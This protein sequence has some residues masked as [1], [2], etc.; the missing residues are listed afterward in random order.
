MEL[1]IT[2]PRVEW[3]G[4]DIIADHDDMTPQ[5]WRQLRRSGIGGSDAGAIMQVSRYASPLTVC[6]EKTGRGEDF[7]G[8]EATEV[9]NILEPLIRDYIVVP[10]L[11]DHGVPIKDIGAAHHTYR[12]KEWPWMLANIDG[13]IDLDL[14]DLGEKR[15]GLEIKTG[16]SFQLKDWGGMDGDEIPETYYAQVQHYMA[17][18][19]VTEWVVFGLIGNRRV[20]R[21]VHRNETY[22]AN[23]VEEEREV[24]RAIES[25]DPLQFPAPIGLDAED[26]AIR[27]LTTPMTDE[28]VDLSHIETIIDR[29]QSLSDEIKDMTKAKKEAQQII[30]ATMGTAKTGH[31][32]RYTV[33]RTAYVKQQFDAAQYAKDHPDEVADYMREIEIDFPRVKEA[34]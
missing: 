25:N 31:A 32:G 14:D 2:R 24:W 7:D 22:I 15:I 33:T 26:A 34:K 17:V 8:N 19:G 29:Y 13:F 28:E 18:T 27:R 11:E 21:P 1:T 20:Y 6:M 4:C 10:Y 5:E 30:K 12:S 9:G 3:P 16:G 23:L